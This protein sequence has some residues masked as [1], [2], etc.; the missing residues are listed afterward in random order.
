MLAKSE[1][2]QEET[3]PLFHL[4]S[5]TAKRI[6]GGAP[7]GVHIFNQ[8]SLQGA[9]KRCSKSEVL[10]ADGT[11]LFRPGGR[12]PGGPGRRAG[13]GGWGGGGDPDG[14]SRRLRPAPATSGAEAS[15]AN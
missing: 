15:P 8:V 7:A 12:A 2:I 6:H 9:F 1:G 4:L 13:E 10:G 5:Y 3:A 11:R 14:G